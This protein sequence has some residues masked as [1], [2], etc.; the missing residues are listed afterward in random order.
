MLRAKKSSGWRTA[1]V[2]QELEGELLQIERHHDALA[3]IDDLE[4]QCIR[5]DS[6]IA[7]QQ[8]VL[9]SLQHSE[10]L[11][12]RPGPNG[13]TAREAA[14]IDAAKIDTKRK[15][16][17]LKQTMKT[18]SSE[19]ARLEHEVDRSFNSYWGP[20]FREGPENSRFAEQVE[21]Y[22]CVYTSRVSNFLA[23]SPLRYFRTPRAQMPHELV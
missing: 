19:L 17:E 7:Y 1:M 20:I 15:L 11:P 12:K 2:L 10:D 4:R 16:D 3:R 21:S 8:M 13:V 14:Q 9:K 5:L 23:Y 18:A 22:A 6:D